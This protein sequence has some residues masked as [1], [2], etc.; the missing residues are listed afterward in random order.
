MLSEM[1]STTDAGFAAAIDPYRREL[2]AYCRGFV[3]DDPTAD[4]L[5]Q[6]AIVRAWHARHSFQ[7][8]SSLRTWLYRIASNVCLDELRRD[9]LRARPA[10]LEALAAASIRGDDDPE[11]TVVATETLAGTILTAVQHLPPRQR[12]V[13]VLRDGLG[14]SADQTASAMD[15]S[16]AAANSALQRAREAIRRHASVEEPGLPITPTRD[17][18]EAVARCVDLLQSGPPAHSTARDLGELLCSTS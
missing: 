18:L 12:A 5:A 6:E 9:R 10:D 17:E 15:C 2:R 16:T 14:W 13:L 11:A 4:D 8:R 7:G 1:L 3:R